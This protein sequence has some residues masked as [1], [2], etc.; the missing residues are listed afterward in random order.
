MRPHRQESDHG[1]LAMADKSDQISID[2]LPGTKQLDCGNDIIGAVLNRRLQS[3]ALRASHPPVVD[4]KNGDSQRD[5]VP[6]KHIEE[7]ETVEAGVAVLVAAAADQDHRGMQAI[8]IGQR[9]VAGQDHVAAAE[10]HLMASIGRLRSLLHRRPR[11]VPARSSR[12]VPCTP[13]WVNS[14]SITPSPS[15]PSHTASPT[16]RLQLQMQAASIEKDARQLQPERTLGRNVHLS[17]DVCLGDRQ[18]DRERQFTQTRQRGQPLPAS[19][20]VCESLNGIPAGGAG[21]GARTGC[22]RRRECRC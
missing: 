12:N 2:V 20:E 17:S 16:G 21:S 8:A 13:A 22:G 4:A 1:P 10:R 19:L 15:R 6:G 3:V 7:P 18:V 5:Y 11:P 9:Q 14:P